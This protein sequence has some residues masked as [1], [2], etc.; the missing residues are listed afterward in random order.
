MY[1]CYIIILTL[2][3]IKVT[4][5]N[6]LELINMPKMIPKNHWEQIESF[7]FSLPS[8]PRVPQTQLP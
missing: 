7:F 2:R 4:L 5:F 1:I 6:I 8:P 3:F